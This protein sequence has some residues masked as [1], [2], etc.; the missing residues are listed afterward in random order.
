MTKAYGSVME[1]LESQ[2]VPIADPDREDNDEEGPLHDK[3][4]GRADKAK[5]A[6]IAALLLIVAADAATRF[7]GVRLSS[8]SS[9]NGEPNRWVPRGDL[10]NAT[11]ASEGLKFVRDVANHGLQGLALTPDGDVLFEVHTLAA[12]ALRL[13]PATG[14]IEGVLG[15][16]VWYGAADF[17]PLLPIRNETT[18]VAHIGGVDV[19]TSANYGTELWMAT[20]SDGIDGVGGLF[21]V[22]T[23]SLDI[24]P[25][26][27]VLVDY[28]L[29][30]VACRDGVLYF[31]E[32]FGVR[33]IH[34]ADLDTLERLEDLP[35]DFS[36]FDGEFAR[37]GVDWIDYVQSAAFDGES[38]L[39]LLG[40]DYQNTIYGFDVGENQATLKYT[41]GLLLGSETDGIAFDNKR[42][43]MLVGYNRQHSHE[44]VMGLDPM[45]SIIELSRQ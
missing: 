14:A 19:C 32:F 15:R 7:R 43:R 23:A 41:Q 24:L 10:L 1:A 42:H 36:S 18:S 38:Q 25:H 44:Q 4:G 8:P 45:I 3:S 28:N 9:T 34:R 29:D 5:R 12:R 37:R 35:L 27:R 2:R 11:P 13:D 21:A 17:P 6:L 16:R 20:H 26:R 22:D 30:W 33:K 40:D 39:V 31:G